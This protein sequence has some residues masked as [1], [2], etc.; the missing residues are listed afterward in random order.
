M[1]LSLLVDEDSQA[2]YLVNLLKSAGHD[3]LTVNEAHLS[4]APD[5][6]VFAFA[7]DQGRILL[8]R[9]CSDF[10]EIHQIQPNHPGIL[11][12]YQN[13]DASKN[14]SYQDIVKAIQNLEAASLDIE[15]QFIVLNQWNY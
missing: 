15:S 11:A 2:K 8:T 10:Q 14:L 9:N 12:V 7:R 5:P 1:S 3:V 13:T 4:G 6:S